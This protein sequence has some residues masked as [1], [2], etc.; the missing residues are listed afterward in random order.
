MELRIKRILTLLQL[1]GIQYSE[2][3]FIYKYIEI[4]VLIKAGPF[5]L[6]KERMTKRLN[7]RGI[8][9]YMSL[10]FHLFCFHTIH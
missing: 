7:A 1:L 3:F 10:F 8:V 5:L 9:G 6:I 4:H 2:L